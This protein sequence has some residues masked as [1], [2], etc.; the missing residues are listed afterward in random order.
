[1]SQPVEITETLSI[2]KFTT[3][4]GI[5][6]EVLEDKV[7]EMSWKIRLL[8]LANMLRSCK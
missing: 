8:I 6:S 2:R 1:M 7:L 5:L 4:H 3:K